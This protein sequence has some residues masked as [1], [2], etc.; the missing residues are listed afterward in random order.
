MPAAARVGDPDNSDGVLLSSGAA[1][2][3]RINGIPAALVGTV[4]QSHSPYGPPHP[5]HDAATVTQGSSTVRIEGIPAARQGDPLS[6]D[7]AIAQGS[8]DVNIGG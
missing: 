2:T 8:P 1:Q 5:P 4:D 6:C 3:V 7:H